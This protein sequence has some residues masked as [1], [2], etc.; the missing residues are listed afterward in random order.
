VASGL[1]SDKRHVVVTYADERGG[2]LPGRQ[3]KLCCGAVKC[4]SS[5]GSGRAVAK[6]VAWLWRNSWRETGESYRASS[7]G[8]DGGKDRLFMSSVFN[9][10]NERGSVDADIRRSRSPSGQTQRLAFSF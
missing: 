7:R 8:E 10:T 1:R 5:A 2:F 6:V 3:K 9:L 4:R